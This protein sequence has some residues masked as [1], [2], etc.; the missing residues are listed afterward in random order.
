MYV[1]DLLILN[2]NNSKWLVLNFLRAKIHLDIFLSKN[3][4]QKFSINVLYT[5]R[6]ATYIQDTWTKYFTYRY[7][8]PTRLVK[9]SFRMK[10]IQRHWQT[11]STISLSFVVKMRLTIAQESYSQFE[12]IG[13]KKVYACKEYKCLK[14]K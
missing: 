1:P 2:V 11:C 14:N 5:F 4:C 9:I 6:L 13:L 10:D 12:K 8:I 3:I 7:Q